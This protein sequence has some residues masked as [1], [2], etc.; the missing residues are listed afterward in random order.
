MAEFHYD[1]P[2]A[3]MKLIGVTG[4]NGKTTTTYLLREI[5]R[6]AKM[7]IGMIGTIQY[8]FGSTAIA[9]THTTPT[10]M[11]LQT[12]FC[13][14]ADAGV[15]TVIIEISSHALY[16]GRLGKLQ[17]DSAIFTNL[18]G[19]HL[20]YH[21]SMENYY[22]AKRGMFYDHLK[23]DGTAIIN[24]DDN[25]GERLASELQAYHKNGKV[26]TFGFS[27][28]ASW[29]AIDCD[30]NIN[31][32]E[33]NL[34]NGKVSLNINSPLIG[35]F[36]AYNI[37]GALFLTSAPGQR[38]HSGPRGNWSSSED[39]RPNPLQASRHPG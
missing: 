29:R 38:Q 4:T 32:C 28:A 33:M 18:T 25:Y 31:T 10:P 37:M 16:Q 14:M 8:T 9:S 2:S 39:A 21:E 36:N 34:E 22:A 5:L 26:I 24:I 12:L 13:D 7:K 23:P 30:M 1:Y 6:A 11:E 27:N 3:R 20:D 17:L 35:L 19:D 15:D